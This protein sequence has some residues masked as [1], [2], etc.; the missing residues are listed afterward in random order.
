M[1]LFQTQERI[2][3]ELGFN[4]NNKNIYMKTINI[5]KMK[6]GSILSAFL[7]VFS[8]SCADLEEEPGETII[9]PEALTSVETLSVLVTGMYRTVQNDARWSDFYIAGFGGDDITTHSAVNKVGFRE[10][11]WRSQTSL[12]ERINRAWDAPYSMIAIANSA[13]NAVPNIVVSEDQQEFFDRIVGEAYFMRA[14][15]Y[16][17][18]TRTY[19]EVVINLEVN[20]LEERQLSSI[21]EVYQ[22][23]ESDL[24][25][26]EALLP[27]VYP[28]LAA[29][30][31][32]PSKGAAK[33]FLARLYMHWA[34]FPVND[35]SKYAL[36]ATKAKE[37]ID[38]PYGYSLAPSMREMWTVANRFNHDE[39]VF[40]LAFCD[41]LCDIGNRASGRLGFPADAGGWSEIFGE[42]AF[43]EDMEADAMAQG[44][45]ARFEDTYILEVI[46]R[47]DRPDASDWRNFSN[48]PH[49]ILRKV[50]GGDMAEVSLVVN[51]TNTPINR[52]FMR[53]ADVLLTYAEAAGRSGNVTAD[54]W[55]ALNMVRRRA[56]GLDPN[57][58]D[59][60]IDLTSG[61]LAE[62]AFTERKWE[63]AGEYERWHDLVRMDRV[64]EAFANRSPDERV[65]V[66]NS[67][68]PSATGP[69]VY[70]TP[71]PQSELNLQPGLAN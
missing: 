39:G 49:P 15:A 12:S 10:A 45:M 7:M 36:A 34:G 31:V 68:T 26:A 28:G 42:I 8:F 38:G 13:I 43:F 59:A 48:E 71:I 53:Y 60:S 32:R 6:V 18:L 9:S 17:H 62:L 65:D 20:S 56:A 57:S 30:G 2:H 23:V 14:F 52:Y 51:S 54:A 19:G 24:L 41:E 16:L 27:D 11:D 55:E 37:V 21:E 64:A 1:E 47:R 63:L 70:Y 33:G 61:D 67:K 50:G 25:Q 46:P 35:T 40:T 5:R 44:T 69:S 22:Q 3:L 58:P 4:F 29:V 66:V